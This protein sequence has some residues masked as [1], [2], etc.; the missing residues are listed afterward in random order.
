MYHKS[1]WFAPRTLLV[2][3]LGI[4]IFFIHNYTEL[5]ARHKLSKSLLEEALKHG[6]VK[7]RTV[8]CLL[9]GVAGA[10]KTHIKHILLGDKPPKSRNSTPLAEKPVRAVRVSANCGQLQEVNLDQLDKRVA[11]TVATAD[12]L[13]SK[14]TFLHRILHCI[15]FENRI[16][17]NKMG[18]SS[19]S[20]KPQSSIGTSE[21]PY[22]TSHSPKKPPTTSTSHTKCLCCYADSEVQTITKSLLDE[23]ASN[24]TA[25]TQQCLDGD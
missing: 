21:R 11:G 12:S 6:F 1:I 19:H 5:E 7:C 18:L 3:W 2:F 24:I 10:G 9:V 17:Y 13:K 22:S 25:A 23:T 15:C 16:K 20:N 14:T 4:S 8:V